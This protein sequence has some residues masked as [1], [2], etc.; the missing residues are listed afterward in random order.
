MPSELQQPAK[1]RSYLGRLVS[2]FVRITKPLVH[3]VAIAYELHVDTHLAPQ[4]ENAIFFEDPEFARNAIPASAY[5]NTRSGTISVGRD[6][7]FGEGVR[8]LTG[9]HANVREAETGGVPLHTVPVSGRDIVIGRGCYIGSG[10]T[11][12]GPLRIGD[13]A[14][15]GAGSVVTKDVA[16]RTFVAGVPARV[17]QQL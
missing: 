9:K 16:P 11:L 17:I 6:T 1:R 5:F 15:V 12:I 10:A 7:V 4:G 13:Y 14:V 3:R 8:V 2:V